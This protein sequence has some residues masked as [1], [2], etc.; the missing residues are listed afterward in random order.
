MKYLVY[1]ILLSLIAYNATAQWVAKNESPVTQRHHGV[2]FTVGG[3]AYLVSGT[4]IQSNPLG[5]DNFYRY[6]KEADSWTELDRFPGGARSYAYAGVYNDKAYFGFGTNDNATFYN[7]LWEF[8]PVTEEWTEL[9]NCPCAGRTHPAFVVH[10]GKIYVGL[11]GSA[12]GDR[13]DWWEY[14]IETDSWTM[15]PSLPGPRRHHPFHFSA[16]GYVYAG[17]GHQ[18]SNFYAD[19]YR[20]D[21]E[22]NTWTQMNDHPG[23]PRVAGQEFSHNGYG[24]V[25]SGDGNNHFNLLEGEFWRYE[26]EDDTWTRMP[27]HP[28]GAISD[29]RKGRWAPGS[30]VL[31]DHVYFFGGVNRGQGVLFGD[32]Y[33]FQL[34][35]LSSVKEQQISEVSIS[36]NPANDVIFLGEEISSFS[37]LSINIYELS[38]KLIQS[39]KTTSNFIP[40]NDISAGM[41]IM[42][43]TTNNNEFY[44]SKFVISR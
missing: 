21:T 26:H 6:N 38:G 13:N 16:G 15:R 20:Y 5:T 40:V 28:G 33:S 41:Y 1:T 19:W 32:M 25:I 27:N 35:T 36:P 37:E 29:P 8:D 2:T 43:I 3:S 39:T 9:S 10:N 24:Y 42:N 7:D 4:T 17:F 22:S 44:T 30:F 18:G 14:D 11:G 31:D 34:E 12:T 23:G